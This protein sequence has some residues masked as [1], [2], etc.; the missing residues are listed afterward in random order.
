VRVILVLA[1]CAAARAERVPG[2]KEPV[3]ILR[4]RWGV[5]HIYAKNQADLFFAQGYM[6][7]KDRL[8][9]IDLWRRAG[10]GKLAEVRGSSAVGRD[11]IARL[12][13]FRGDWNQEWSSYAP[14]AREIITAFTNGI[15]AYIRSLNGKQP[16]EFTRAGYDPGLWTPEDVVSRAAALEVVVNIDREIER[17]RS[18]ARYGAAI[19][20]KFIPTDPFVK[21]TLS[22]DVDLRAIPEELLEDYNAAASGLPGAGGSN[23]WVVDGTKSATGKPLLAND[24]HRA[25]TLPSL[26]KTWHLVAPGWDIIGA[27][28]PALPGIEIG[29]NDQI[30][31]GFTI[32]EIDQQDLFV[33]KTNPANPNQ[34]MQ[35]GAWTAMKIERE[36]IAVRGSA[37]VNVELKFTAHGPVIYED[38][39]RHLAYALKWVGSDAGGAAYLG[40][41]TSARA[42]TWDEFTRSM[43]RFKMPSENM[44]YADRAGNIGYIVAGA[45]P[46]RAQGNGLLPVAGDSGAFDWTGYIP[47]AQM[48]RTYNPSRHYLATANNNFLAPGDPRVFSFDFSPPF[49]V[50]RLDNLLARTAKFT[51][52]DFERIQQDVVSVPALRFQALVRNAKLT[53]ATVEEFLKWDGRLTADSRSGLI[54]ELWTSELFREIYPPGWT[55]SISMDV[56]LKELE[57]RPNPKLL[58]STLDN[59]MKDLRRA[60]PDPAQWTWS[61]A[62][63]L[64]LRH[65]LGSPD[66]DVPPVTRPGD[67]YTINAAGSRGAAGASY[68]QIIDVGDWD[69]SVMTNAPGESGDPQSRHYKDLFA[70]WAAGRYHPMPYSRKA[71]EAAMEERIM[72]EPSAR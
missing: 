65:P 28:E 15:N 47:A 35:R 2:L 66:L 26:R 20:E 52:A 34:Y 41:L 3:E 55:T 56:L 36:Q 67:N 17:A 31:F 33:E 14:D 19:T 24:P 48:P 25:I 18:M 13:R 23:N 40:S 30:A 4:D 57:T 50:Q 70:D 37:P 44:V 6:S 63:T 43:E 21:L 53:G 7:A 59:A 60:L 38:T 10:Q 5:P 71:V 32:A 64:R 51:V 29:H 11:R 22:P 68:R 39:A 45:T 49:R 27:G 61:A 58:A 46:V 12:L 9:Q 16:L 69:N 42:K 72:L 62:Q 1:L 54:F 8:Y